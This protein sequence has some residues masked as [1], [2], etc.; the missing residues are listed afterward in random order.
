MYIN[1]LSAPLLFPCISEWWL[2]VTVTPED[3]KITV[4]NNGNSKGLIDSIPK[5]G[6]FA[7]SSTVGDNAL[8][9]N[10]QKIAKK[11][12]AS[13]TINKPTPIF[14]PLCTASVWLP[15]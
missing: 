13:D 8:W 4:F 12:N 5:G 2:Y 15:K 9:K 14:K 1:P 10:D 11:N 7:P 6:H 3:N